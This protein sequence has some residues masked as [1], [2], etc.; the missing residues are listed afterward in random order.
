MNLV[1]HLMTNWDKSSFIKISLNADLKSK[2]ERE[3]EYLNN[4]YTNIPLRTRAYVLVNHIT[5]D[6]I[7][8]CKCGCERVCAIDMTYSVNG[9]RSY[10]GPECSRKSERLPKEVLELLKDKDWLYNQRITQKKSIE[11]IANDL[12]ISHISVKKWMKIHNIDLMLDCRRRNSL[13]SNTLDNKEKLF[14]LYDSGLTCEEIAET[15]STTKSTVSRWIC[16]HNIETRS[17]NSYDRKIN[18]VS[19]EENTLVEFIKNNYDGKII[20]SNRTILSGRE[21]DIYLPD[22]KIA[23]EYNGLYS[24]YYRPWESSK[25]LIKDS[26]YHLSKTNECEKQGIQLLQIFS[27][28]W[29]DKKLIVESI[30]KSKL[31]INERV[32]ARKCK[33]VEVDVHTKNIFLNNYHIQGEDK[34][35]FKIGLEYDN[36]LISVMTFTKSR[37]NKNY[38]WELS[39]FCTRSEHNVIGGF[40]KLLKYFRNIHSG[41]II[42]YADRRYSNGN[43]YAINGFILLHTND[44][45]Y[46]Y[47]DKNCLERHNRMKFQKKLIDANNCTEYERARQLGYNK[48]FDCGSLAYGLS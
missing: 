44:P 12:G 28:E 1:D 37:F 41:S 48:I 14:E 27:D 24:H 17:P 40:S 20:T 8:K 6:K 23:I 9:F 4:Y 34:S 13:A 16:L 3:T 38:E 11:L 43:V 39:R 31:N 42:S 29:K 10:S 19:K 18:R 36:K 21:L 7:P 22:K 32:Y 33:I 2:I 46:Y 45:S 47:V 26:K 30:I 5:E 25:S 15:L 35:K